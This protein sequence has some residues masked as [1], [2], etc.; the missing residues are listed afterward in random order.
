VPLIVG[1]GAACEIA[2]RDLERNA[3]H[4][5]AMRDRL[6]QGLAAELEHMRLNGHAE[7]RLPNTLSLGFSDLQAPRLLEVLEGVA[8]SAG[9]ACHAGAVAASP[10]L[11]AMKVPPALAAGTIR[12]STGRSTSAEDIDK[13]VAEI[14]AAARRLGGR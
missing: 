13:A 5:R 11:L 10:V 8:A 2:A 7:K 3:A 4:M 14:V 6:H 12:F 9:A 1:L